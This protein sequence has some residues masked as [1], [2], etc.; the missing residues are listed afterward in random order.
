[1]ALGTA[2]LSVIPYIDNKEDTARRAHTKKLTLRAMMAGFVIVVVM[3]QF[4]WL[5]LDV[6]WYKGI[7]ILGGFMGG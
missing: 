3:V 2:P 1:M 5:P 6:I 4:L 7:R